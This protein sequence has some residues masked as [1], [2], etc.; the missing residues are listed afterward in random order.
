MSAFLVFDK[1]SSQAR[2]KFGYQLRFLLLL[3]LASQLGNLNQVF[4]YKQLLYHFCAAF[5]VTQ[6]CGIPNFGVSTNILYRV[7]IFHRLCKLSFRP[8]RGQVKSASGQH[9]HFLYNFLGIIS[10]KRLGKLFWKLI[11]IYYQFLKGTEL[12][13]DLN[14]SFS[15][16]EIPA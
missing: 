11:Q 12:H 13:L 2:T 5:T 15:I 1:I 10:Q 6:K 8:L 16:R 9:F 4:V 3:I 7:D 14:N